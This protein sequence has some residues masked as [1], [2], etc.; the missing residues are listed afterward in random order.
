MFHERLAAERKKN[1]YTQAELANIIGVTPQA[2][3]K[4]EKGLSLPDLYIIGKLAEL[5]KVSADYLIGSN[6]TNSQSEVIINHVNNYSGETVEVYNYTI[7]LAKVK[8][9]K[10]ALLVLYS[11]NFLFVFLTLI[12]SLFIKEYSALLSIIPFLIAT[13]ALADFPRHLRQFKMLEDIRPTELLPY[14]K[15][16]S[17]PIIMNLMGMVTF[18][19]IFGLLYIS[20][21]NFAILTTTLSGITALL[22]LVSAYTTSFFYTFALL[23]NK[24]ELTIKPKEIV[25]PLPKKNFLIALTSVILFFLLFGSSIIPMMG[26]KAQSSSSQIAGFKASFTYKGHNGYNDNDSFF[27]F[28]ATENVSLNQIVIEGNLYQGYA[29]INGATYNAATG[30]SREVITINKPTLKKGER[31]EI[32]YNDNAPFG[33]AT[34]IIYRIRLDN[35]TYVPTN[36]TSYYEWRATN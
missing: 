23:K 21:F 13:F 30:T 8:K 27:T 24:L 3:S 1:N 5:F 33:M 22:L 10:I 29:K 25:K 28:E 35:I 19:Y 16:G 32:H 4:W 12:G 14:E 11:L 6:Q 2:I 17:S 7:S 36:E 31:L 34:G 20:D 9:R 18:I 26:I 15:R